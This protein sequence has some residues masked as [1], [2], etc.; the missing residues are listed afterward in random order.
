MQGMRSSKVM[1]R[2]R[3]TLGG[4]KVARIAKI[5]EVFIKDKSCQSQVEVV[6]SNSICGSEI[7]QITN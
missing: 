1:P 7:T 3:R 4:R 2:S 5:G 6:G